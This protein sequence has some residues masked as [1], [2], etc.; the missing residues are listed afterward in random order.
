MSLLDIMQEIKESGF[1]PRKDAAGGSSRIPAGEYPVVVTDLG[2]NVAD[3]GWEY[4]QIQC[5]ILDGDFAG[6]TEY[7]SIHFMEEW[8]G[9][10]TPRFVLERN[11]KLA[12]K[13]ATFAEIK[14]KAADW[15]DG[16]SIGEMLKPAIGLQVMLD[17]K[18]TKNKK[19]PDNPYRNY[20]FFEL[21]DT[22]QV[23]KPTEISDEDLPF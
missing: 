11:L 18:E 12:R 5:E 9:K 10:E 17:I 21:D 22:L 8:K 6:Q 1:D 14:Q 13:L 7:V 2:F 19:D 23:K 15:E 4:I 16:Y 20:D 3:S